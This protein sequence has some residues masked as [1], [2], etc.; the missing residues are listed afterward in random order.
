MINIIPNIPKLRSTYANSYLFI[1]IIFGCMLP[2]LATAL[3][4]YTQ[5]ITFS[6]QNFF[7][8]QS[9]QP[10]HW[11]IDTAPFVLGFIARLA[12]RRQDQVEYLNDLL[13]QEVDLQTQEITMASEEI[14]EKDRYGD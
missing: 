8:L 3:D 2:I 4:L 14:E 9:Q 1:G 10:L 5:A 6:L 13:A 12:G 7:F 11:I